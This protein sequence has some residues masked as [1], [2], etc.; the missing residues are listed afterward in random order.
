MTMDE[1]KL[2][3]KDK[4]V[5]AVLLSDATNLSAFPLAKLSRTSSGGIY[6]LLARLERNDLVTSEWQVGPEP[7]RRFYRL[8]PEGR[9]W[10]L[11]ALGLQE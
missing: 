4:R 10:A 2:S 3:D 6:V 8:T 9:T 7:R 5:L 11:D 1:I